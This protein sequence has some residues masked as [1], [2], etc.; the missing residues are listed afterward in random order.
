MDEVKY[1]KKARVM[2]VHVAPGSRA[3]KICR[4]YAGRP[5]QP[6]QPEALARG[7]PSTPSHDLHDRGG[8]VIPDLVFTNFFLGGT[9]AWSK[10]DTQRIDGAL[11]AAMS[12][13]NLNNVMVQY[14]R[15]AQITSAFRPSQVLSEHAQATFSRDDVEKRIRDLHAAGQL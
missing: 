8:K 11:A 12:D 5:G 7:I 2:R 13:H 15:G 4:G 14:F 6:V 10:D 3:E 9:S 1:E